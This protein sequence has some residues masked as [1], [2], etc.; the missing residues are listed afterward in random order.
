[1]R[2]IVLGDTHGRDAFKVII[3]NEKWDRVIF[4]GDYFDSFDIPAEK[5]ISNFQDIMQFKRDNIDKVVCLL[6]NHCF[7]YL[8]GAYEDYSGFQRKYAGAIGALF[9]DALAD[10]L[11][12]YAHSYKHFLFT[13]A[14]V[15]KY[16]LDSTG[17][18]PDD[19]NIIEWINQ[20]NLKH[21]RFN[22]GVNFSPYGDDI[23]QGPLW[24]RPASLLKDG[25]KDWTHVVGHTGMEKIQFK[26]NCIFTDTLGHSGEYLIID[27]DE[28]GNI[29]TN[30]NSYKNFL[31]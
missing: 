21:F 5:Q 20:L 7:H 29:T 17:Y 9:A 6:G 24:I 14:G 25:L 16:W 13:H 11:L 4:I 15:S 22:M 8:H 10:N 30:V 1:M 12:Q 23:C 19:G 28:D 2:T 27:E 3:N 26:D 31:T 18:T